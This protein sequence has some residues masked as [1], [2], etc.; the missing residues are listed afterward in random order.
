MILDI[1]FNFKMAILGHY[2]FNINKFYIKI[3]I[4]HYIYFVF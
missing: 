3:H 1:L 4:Y 2:I